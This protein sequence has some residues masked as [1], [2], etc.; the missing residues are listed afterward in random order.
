MTDG[1]GLPDGSG[2]VSQGK[3][4]YQQ[5]CLACHGVEGKN[6][7]NDQLV[8][9][10]GTLTSSRP[11]R[12]I[13]SYWPYATTIFDFIRRAMPYQNP[14]SL[15]HN[16]VYALT[17]YLLYL[18]EIVPKSTELTATNLV[19]IKMPNEKNFVQHYPNANNSN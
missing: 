9:G 2:T 6:G 7:I 1:T 14:G 11:V 8:G 15:S 17:A 16:D 13:G 4:L 12:T 3:T 5:H 18:N 19:D 10:Q